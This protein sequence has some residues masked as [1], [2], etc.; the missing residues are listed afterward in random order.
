[1]SLQM[2]KCPRCGHENVSR[3]VFCFQCGR[4]LEEPPVVRGVHGTGTLVEDA[5][6]FIKERGHTLEPSMIERLH[7]AKVK[8]PPTDIMGVPLTCLHC[9]TYNKPLAAKCTACGEPLIVPDL[10]TNLV[11][12]AGALSNVGRVRSNNED[13]LNLWAL[14]GVVLAVVADGMGGAAAG[15]EASR[16]AVEAVQAD[17]L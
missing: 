3:A 13:S 12:H 4:D 14:E 7:Q 9:G 1:M 16:L 2:R 10:D 15:E 6:R 8:V 17:F 11:V 5:L